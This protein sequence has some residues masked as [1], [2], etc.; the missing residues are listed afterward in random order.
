MGSCAILFLHLLFFT[1][2][3]NLTI[4]APTPKIYLKLAIYLSIVN[5]NGNL[6]FIVPGFCYSY[7]SWISYFKCKYMYHEVVES[8]S[9]DTS[10]CFESTGSW[11]QKYFFLESMI[12]LFCNYYGTGKNRTI[13]RNI[14]TSDVSV[15]ELHLWRGRCIPQK[16]PKPG[17]MDYTAVIPI[18]SDTT[19]V[20]L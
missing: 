20:V 2:K 3:I 17:V 18:P 10:W 11:H 6:R 12:F 16:K 1:L 4:G 19:G 14:L 5:F 13:K 8:G 7:K 15:R 9:E